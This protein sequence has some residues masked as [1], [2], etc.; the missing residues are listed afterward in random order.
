MSAVCRNTTY[1]QHNIPHRL[2]R[3]LAWPDLSSDKAWTALKTENQHGRQATTA[4]VCNAQ[5]QHPQH[6]SLSALHMHA[7]DCMQARHPATK[8]NTASQPPA[9]CTLENDDEPV[10]KH[11]L[12]LVQLHKRQGK[13]GSS[14]SL[15]VSKLDTSSVSTCAAS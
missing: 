7:A 6:Q 12:V 3:P 9:T 13:H 5:H 2:L 11:Q 15:P 8:I 4:H 1:P 10:Q 14:G